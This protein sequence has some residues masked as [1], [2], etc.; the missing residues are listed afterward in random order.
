MSAKNE[1]YYT[2]DHEWLE[3]LDEKNVRIGITEYAVEQL[4]DV[5]YVELPDVGEELDLKEEFST[6]E[7]VK[8]SSGI[9]SPVVGTVLKINEDLEEEPELMNDSPFEDGWII[10]VSLSEPLNKDGL[11]SYDAYIA[12]TETLD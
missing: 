10:E 2:D 4:G 3:V 5:V 1:F 9:F 12:Y 7:S 6:V 11:L 8:S